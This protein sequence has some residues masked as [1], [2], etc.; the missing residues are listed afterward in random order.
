MAVSL[1][2]LKMPWLDKNRTAQP[3]R[4]RTD[5]K[6]GESV[7]IQEWYRR[8][9]DD[10]K[11]SSVACPYF[12]PDLDAIYG[13]AWKSV[14]DGSELSSRSNRTEHNKRNGVIDVGDKFWSETGDDIKRTEELMGYD[15]SLIG[16]PEFTWKDRS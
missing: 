14:V 10:R 6:T 2:G 3:G 13:G 8:N 16:A 12:M 15:P 9:P 7:T 11:R 5:K 4:Y 1:S